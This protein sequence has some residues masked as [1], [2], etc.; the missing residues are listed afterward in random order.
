MVFVLLM[1]V[2]LINL[3]EHMPLVNFTFDYFKWFYFKKLS[4][5]QRAV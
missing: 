5:H 1:K 4:K 2:E 3:H